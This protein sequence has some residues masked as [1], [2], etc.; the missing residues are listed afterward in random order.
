VDGLAHR[1]GAGR[2][3][4]VN[5]AFF[6]QMRQSRQRRRNPDALLISETWPEDQARLRVLGDEFDSDDELPLPAGRARLPA[7]HAPSTTDD[8]SVPR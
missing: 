4:Q 3:E 7:R 5:P 6:E 8:G 1:R 2:G